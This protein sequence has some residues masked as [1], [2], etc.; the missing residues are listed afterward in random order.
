MHRRHTVRPHIFSRFDPEPGHASTTSVSARSPLRILAV[1]MVALVA[2]LAPMPLAGAQSDVMVIEFDDVKFA[3]PGSVVPAGSVSTPGALVG[4]TCSTTIST[5][6]QSSIHPDNDLL[7]ST[8]GQTARIEDVEDFTDG[9]NSWLVDLTLGSTIE[10]AVVM[11]PD[12][13]TSLGFSVVVDCS[14]PL[15]GST[16]PVLASSVT[17]TIPATTTTEPPTTAP[18]TTEPPTTEPPTTSAPLTT[19]PATTASTEPSTTDTTVPSTTGSTTTVTSAPST[20]LQVQETTT[21][22]ESTTIS[23]T[24]APTVTVPSTTSTTA[25]AV[26]V[27]STQAPQGELEQ[28]GELEETPPALAVP[29]Q[30]SYTG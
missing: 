18:P 29:A 14:K 5:A 24:A 25:E 4:T 6:N 11:G 16:V 21:T 28:E 8:G 26:T 1:V 12:G 2:T 13:I 10:I 27:T 19:A 20:Q 15:V 9:T 23:S 7:L 22:T 3:P 17:T 30:P